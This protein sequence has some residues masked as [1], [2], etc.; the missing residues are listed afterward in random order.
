MNAPVKS[1]NTSSAPKSS[2]KKI[3]VSDEELLVLD[4]TPKWNVNKALSGPKL[5]TPSPPKAASAKVVAKPTAP[6]QPVAASATPTAAV[7]KDISSVE[8]ELERL[9]LQSASAN[10]EKKTDWNS[11]DDLITSLDG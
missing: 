10:P 6:K 11:L 8:D 9:I 4:E 7:K 1:N 2:Q 3:A 5:A